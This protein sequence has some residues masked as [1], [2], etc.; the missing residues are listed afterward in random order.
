MSTL[1]IL[2]RQD[3]KIAGV[4]AVVLVLCLAAV[5]FSWRWSHRSARGKPAANYPVR[6]AALARDADQLVQSVEAHLRETE[7]PLDW[8]RL[9]V[10]QE[11]TRAAVSNVVPVAVVIAPTEITWRLRGTARAGARPVAFV[12][13]RTMELGDVID[14]YTLIDISA[15]RA[16]L[17][18]PKGRIHVLMIYNEPS[19]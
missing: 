13:D 10:R 18:D 17:R 2:R 11:E 5:G 6:C 4:L 16:T 3:P 12:D 14:G 15:D 19:P 1:H 8:Q 7:A 9:R